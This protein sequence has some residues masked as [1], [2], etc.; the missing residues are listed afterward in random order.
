LKKLLI[1][2]AIFLL[3]SSGV[4]LFVANTMNLK[5]RLRMT[6]RPS[7]TEGTITGKRPENRNRV[8]YRF[9][10]GHRTYNAEGA[11]GDAYESINIGAKVPVIYDAQ[12]PEMSEIYDLEKPHQWGLAS[13]DAV[14]LQMLVISSIFSLMGGGLF[15]IP[16]F[17]IVWGRRSVR[18]G[19]TEQALG[20]DSP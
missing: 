16:A 4:F 1:C 5:S 3:C 7:T 2:L 10:A 11:V 20:A 6:R 9:E 14:F 19:A 15:A 8:T 17:V 12:N 13:P 18:G